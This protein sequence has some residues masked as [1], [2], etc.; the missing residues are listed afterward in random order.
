MH[1][2]VASISVRCM[3]APGWK[4]SPRETH[5]GEEKMSIGNNILQFT[6][7]EKSTFWDRYFESLQ[8]SVTDIYDVSSEDSKMAVAAL[9]VFFKFKRERRQQILILPQ[10]V[11]WVWH[12]FIVDTKIYA[13]FCDV[14][15]GRYLH[16]VK[17]QHDGPAKVFLDHRFQI[18]KSMLGENRKI[19]YDSPFWSDAG[20]KYPKYRL[21][22][23]FHFDEGPTP[24]SDYISP[25][26]AALNLKWIAQR[27][28]ERYGLSA[29]QA[30]STLSQYESYLSRQI[31]RDNYE[32]PSNAYDA[33]W[34]EHIL[35]TVKYHRDCNFL[36]GTYLHRGY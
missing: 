1:T 28:G 23:Y 26:V 11:D 16:H 5:N 4:S 27:L 14:Y 35:A 2:A 24:A 12:E 18:T 7:E 10:I 21:R 8:E 31:E 33:A 36:F 20:W 13:N 30:E 6:N 3:T 25:A 34:K 22:H 15:F 19:D 32:V 17:T 9:L 29:K